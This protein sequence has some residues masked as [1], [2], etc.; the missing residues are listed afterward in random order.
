MEFENVCGALG[1][2]AP[3]SVMPRLKLRMVW[4]RL[5]NFV[6]GVGSIDNVERSPAARFN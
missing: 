6:D 4:L 5:A 1:T 3:Q 2:L